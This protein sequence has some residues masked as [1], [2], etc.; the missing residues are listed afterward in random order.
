[1]KNPGSAGRDDGRVISPTNRRLMVSVAA[2]LGVAAAAPHAMGQSVEEVV[3]TGSRVITNGFQAPTP[4]T[5]VSSEELNL[6]AP[7]SLVDSLNQL[8]Q[9]RGSMQP[10]TTGVGTTGNVGQ[11]FMTLRNLG[12]TR[13]LILFDGKRV[14]PSGTDGVFDVSLLPESL[15][16][17]VEIVTGGRRAA[18]VN[19]A[20]SLR[21]GRCCRPFPRR[22]R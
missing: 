3:V 7:T 11:S 20:H 6:A 10:A 15:V 12:P 21:F 9:F 8:P 18:G 5:V 16:Q 13:T 4:V 19:S 17:R 1:M 2:A 14:V 22:T